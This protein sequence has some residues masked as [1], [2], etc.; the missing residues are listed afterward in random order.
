MNATS[1]LFSLNCKGSDINTID[2]F[3]SRS[4]R[5]IPCTIAGNKNEMW[6]GELFRLAVLQFWFF[7]TLMQTSVRAGVGS[8][9]LFGKSL[10]SVAPVVSAS[11]PAYSGRAHHFL[12]CLI[13]S[14][15]G[16]NKNFPPRWPRHPLKQLLGWLPAE[17]GIS[18]VT[19]CMLLK[20]IIASCTRVSRA[21]S[22]PLG[23]KY[24]SLIRPRK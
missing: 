17:G 8:C 20:C 15:S 7:P 11:W 16:P 3:G 4:Q 1:T 22:G 6:G 10:S 24:D 12:S 18:M 21:R 13:C 5:N 2:G 9:T 23:S 14:Y 19:V